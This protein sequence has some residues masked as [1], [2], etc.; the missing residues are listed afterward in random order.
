MKFKLDEAHSDITALVKQLQ[1]AEQAN[2]AARGDNEL[3]ALLN[4]SAHMLEECRTTMLSAVQSLEEA[5][6][7]RTGLMDSV[8]RADEVQRAKNRAMET[9]ANFFKSLL[10]QYTPTP[11]APR[12]Q[13][14]TSEVI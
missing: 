14:V 8:S 11:V 4:R 6:S 5:A 3:R 2:R 9:A 13:Q 10:Q 12:S 1:E 7:L